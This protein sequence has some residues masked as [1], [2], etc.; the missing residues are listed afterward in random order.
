MS[1][2]VPS[3]NILCRLAPGQSPDERALGSIALAI[4]GHPTRRANALIDRMPWPARRPQHDQRSWPKASI[5][6]RFAEDFPARWHVARIICS[7]GAPRLSRAPGQRLRLA[8]DGLCSIRPIFA[9]TCRRGPRAAK[10][11]QSDP[12]L[13]NE[14]TMLQ[15]MG[16][17]VIP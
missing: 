13:Q 12:S 10:N 7:T 11:K 6:L 17:N 16:R 9:R 15:N 3:D 8:P 4:W 14:A 2:G 5:G 1:R